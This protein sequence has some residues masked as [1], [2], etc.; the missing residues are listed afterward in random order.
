MVIFVSGLNYEQ[1]SGL[2]LSQTDWSSVSLVKKQQTVAFTLDCAEWWALSNQSIHMAVYGIL[3][4]PCYY[5]FVFSSYFFR[6][7]TK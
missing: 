2:T 3:F 6:S 7:K 4:N 5:I 1:L